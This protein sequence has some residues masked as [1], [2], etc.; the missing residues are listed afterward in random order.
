MRG[1]SRRTLLFFTEGELLVKT[2]LTAG[3]DKALYTSNRQSI[4]ATNTKTAYTLAAVGLVGWALMVLFCYLNGDIPQMAYH[5]LFIGVLVLFWSLIP[6]SDE[7]MRGNGWRLPF[8]T[9]LFYLYTVVY[10]TVIVPQH[11]PALLCACLSVLPVLTVDYYWRCALPGMV[12]VAAYIPLALLYCPPDECW[13]NIMH[14]TLALVLG[15]TMAHHSLTVRVSEL[16]LRE[17]LLG[18]RDTDGLTKVMNRRAAEE[19]IRAVLAQSH[20]TSVMIMLDVDNFK[21]IND[22]YGHTYGDHVLEE[23]SAVLRSS[24][25]SSDIISRL[26]GD[27]FMVFAVAVPDEKWAQERAADVLKK[28]S[29]AEL[30]GKGPARVSVSMGIVLTPKYGTGFDELYR[31]ADHALYAAKRQGKN[32]YCV[33]GEA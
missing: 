19:R 27:E 30:L 18:Q 3:M 33:F 16:V 23:L 5:S 2:F 22:Q 7:G 28:L 32:C 8:M 21:R 24:F 13:L 15:V 31:K 12:A 29:Q 11:N 20:T 6:H 25:R 14:V 1:I 9:A 26:G 10:Y 17:R 4:D